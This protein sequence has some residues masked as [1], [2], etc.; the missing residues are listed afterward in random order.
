MGIVWCL[1]WLL[2]VANS[3]SE[4]NFISSKEKA[5]IIRETKDSL[6]SNTSSKT[7]T[8]W[9]GI[10]TSK[11]FYG[12]VITHTCSNFGTYLFLT[13]LPSYMAEVLSF[14]IKSNGMLSSIPYLLFW[15]FTILSGIISD[16]V[17]QSGKLTRST[18]RKLFNTVGFLVPMFAVIGLIFVTCEDPYIGVLFITFGL[19]FT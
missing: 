17:I 4:H 12:L 15:L 16:K 18:V 5:Y 6:S 14:D 7:P 8:P 19:A 9:V 1:L 2:L 3:P 11:A 10:F 13:Q